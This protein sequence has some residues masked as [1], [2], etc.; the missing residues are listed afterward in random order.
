MFQMLWVTY[1]DNTTF[2]ISTSLFLTKDNVGVCTLPTEY[3]VLNGAY[4]NVYNWVAFN[5]TTESAYVLASAESI[6]FLSP[7]ISYLSSNAFFILPLSNARIQ[8]FVMFLTE[9]FF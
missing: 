4:F 7:A 5:P 9:V 8:I 6:K 3:K 1:F 2:S